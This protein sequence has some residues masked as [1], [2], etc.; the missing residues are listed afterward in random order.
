VSYSAARKGQRERLREAGRPPHKTLVK[1]SGSTLLVGSNDFYPEERQVHRGAADGLCANW[2][3]KEFVAR[4]GFRR[5][6]RGAR[7]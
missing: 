7:W 5:V 4:G 1:V 3:R 2:T 6:V